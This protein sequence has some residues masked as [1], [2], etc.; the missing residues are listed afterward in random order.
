MKK[1]HTTAAARILHLILIMSITI[2]V[3][4]NGIV[5]TRAAENNPAGAEENSDAGLTKRE[6][7]CPHR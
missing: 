3:I 7:V 1:T 2:F 6:D 4:C 5:Q